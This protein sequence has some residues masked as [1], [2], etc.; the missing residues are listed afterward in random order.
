[1]V[2][3]ITKEINDLRQTQELIIKTLSQLN[4]TNDV[5]MK[6]LKPLILERKARIEFE[7]KQDDGVYV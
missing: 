7:M 1:M 6:T 5:I 2:R 3:D 4:D